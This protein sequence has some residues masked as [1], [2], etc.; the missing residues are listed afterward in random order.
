MDIDETLLSLLL[1]RFSGLPVADVAD[2][3]PDKPTKFE[4]SFRTKRSA[5]R[6]YPLL[7]SGS[8]GP[9]ACRRTSGESRS[10]PCASLRVHTMLSFSDNSRGDPASP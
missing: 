5:S 7:S 3:V 1:W 10:I 9:T 6:K 4:V 2:I 8:E